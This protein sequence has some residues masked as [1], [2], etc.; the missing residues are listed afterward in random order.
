MYGIE[1][2]VKRCDIIAK[3]IYIVFIFNLF[4]INFTKINSFNENFMLKKMKKNYK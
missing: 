4:G 1:A 2:H 3:K